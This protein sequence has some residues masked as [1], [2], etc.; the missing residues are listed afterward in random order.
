MTDIKRHEKI[1]IFFGALPAKR[2]A[3][4]Q[5]VRNESRYAHETRV[6]DCVYIAAY[7]L[8]LDLALALAL[9]P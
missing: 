6:V 4:E 8:H 1:T 2:H 7:D 3:S 5:R 9:A